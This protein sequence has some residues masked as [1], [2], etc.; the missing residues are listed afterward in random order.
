MFIVSPTHQ[1]SHNRLSVFPPSLPFLRNKAVKASPAVG[2]ASFV[3]SA[4]N[5]PRP[6]AKSLTLFPH[7]LASPELEAVDDH[8]CGANQAGDILATILP[9]KPQSRT[10][11]SP[12]SDLSLVIKVYDFYCRI[13]TSSSAQTITH[14]SIR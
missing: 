10:S 5:P 12:S 13:K 3:A 11:T 6:A 8:V 4:R 7:F 2:V 1:S 9:V 14:N